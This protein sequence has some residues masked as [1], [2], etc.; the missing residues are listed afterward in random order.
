MK[1]IITAGEAI[2]RGVWGDICDVRGYDRQAIHEGKADSTTEIILTI[3][4][5][6][7]LGLIK[8]SNNDSH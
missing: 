5:A 6:K 4:E 2:E 7:D 3:E 8:W 1:I